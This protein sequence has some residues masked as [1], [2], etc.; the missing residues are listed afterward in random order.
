VTELDTSP[1]DRLQMPLNIQAIPTNPKV[2][3]ANATP[4]PNTLKPL[5]MLLF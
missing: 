5:F 2:L 4:D 1:F 3:G